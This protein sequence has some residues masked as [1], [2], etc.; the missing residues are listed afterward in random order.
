MIVGN[1]YWV[2]MLGIVI[3][4]FILYIILWNGDYYYFCFKDEEEIEIGELKKFV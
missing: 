3:K 1:I 2:F 4:Y